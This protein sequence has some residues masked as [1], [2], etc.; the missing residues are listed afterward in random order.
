MSDNSQSSQDG[1]KHEL[2]KIHDQLRDKGYKKLNMLAVFI[3]GNGDMIL[4]EVVGTNHPTINDFD[5]L[6][7]R[8]IEVLNP[9]RYM[10]IQ[11]MNAQTGAFSLNLFML[12]FDCFEEGIMQVQAPAAYW[13]TATSIETQIETLKL[14]LKY[15]EARMINRARS[16]GL[17]IVD[18]KIKG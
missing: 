17:T 8:P 2:E 10:R 13:L 14:L 5:N 1:K 7:G 11:G 15:F 12:D 3:I 6:V 18:S 4:G 16:A 9:K